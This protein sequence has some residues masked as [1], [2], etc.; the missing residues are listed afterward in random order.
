VASDAPP[1]AQYVPGAVHGSQTA[2]DVGVGATVSTVPAA[3]A[4]ATIQFDSLSCDVYVPS[5][6]GSHCR[7]TVALG[8][9][10]TYAPAAHVVHVAQLAE[11]VVSLNVPLAQA[12]HVR[13]VVGLPSRATD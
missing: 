13:S 1:P 2:A 4:S 7:F 6:H 8:C 12:V 9:V 3:H 10:L 11:F 5:P